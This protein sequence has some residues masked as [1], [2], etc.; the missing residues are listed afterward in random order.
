M[1]TKIKKFCVQAKI[2]VLVAIE[3]SARTLDE[4]LEK[5]KTLKVDDFLSVEGDH[6]DSE[7]EIT[8]IY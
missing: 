6:I 5:S 3:L 1:K 4:A 8:G 7:M 2:D